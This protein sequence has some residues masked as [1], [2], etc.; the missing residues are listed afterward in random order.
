LLFGRYH[1]LM[2]VVCEYPNCREVATFMVTIELGLLT[3]HNSYRMPLC[4]GHAEQ[5]QTI[6]KQHDGIAY[7]LSPV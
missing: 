7:R 4:D 6:A 5:A 3:A 1:R 2:V